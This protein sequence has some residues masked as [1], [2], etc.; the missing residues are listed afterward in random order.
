MLKVYG[1][2]TVPGFGDYVFD[3]DENPV[4]STFTAQEWN[5]VIMDMEGALRKISHMKMFFESLKKLRIEADLVSIANGCSVMGLKNWNEDPD[6]PVLQH[7]VAVQVTYLG[8]KSVLHIRTWEELARLQ[9]AIK[10]GGLVAH[11]FMIVKD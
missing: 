2:L 3:A 8:F 9:E 10:Y 11:R 7:Y 6:A 4:E 1:T 5:D